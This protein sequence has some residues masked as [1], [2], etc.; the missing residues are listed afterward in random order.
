MNTPRTAL[1]TRLLEPGSAAD[2]YRYALEQ[3]QLAERLGFAGAWV[4]Q[5]HFHEAEGGL[6]SPFVLLAAAAASTST[7]RLGTGIITLPHEDPVRVAEDAVVLDAISGGRVEL[8]VGSGGTP[9]TFWA[10]DV[11]PADRREVFGSKFDALLGALRGDEL[12]HP[13]NHLYPGGEAIAQRIWQ[14]TFSPQ[15]AALAGARGDG[16]MLS[17]TQPRHVDH[18]R[19]TL[20][21]IQTPVV[22]AYQEALPEGAP[23]R[24]LASRTV[25][26]L[27]EEHRTPVIEAAEDG[28]R[29]LA[30]GFLR[31]DVSGLGLDDLLAITDTVVGTADE[32]IAKLR[33]DVVAGRASE[34]AI[35]MHSVD[36]GHELTLRSL[37]LFATRVAPELGWAQS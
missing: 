22:E 20:S 27:D 3:I 16:L 7:I 13:E 18:P 35:Q 29:R 36:P 5:H 9:A 8:G 25:V 2:R 11:D 10:F 37:E 6:P 14:A 21:E 12:G 4:A 30:A 34:V 17:R 26:V 33:T 19:A 23:R 15:G 24:V 28:L 1:F 31:L 32:V